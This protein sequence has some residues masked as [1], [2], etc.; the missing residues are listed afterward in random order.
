[1]HSLN[2]SVLDWQIMKLTLQLLAS[3]TGSTP[4]RSP[5]LDRKIF[6]FSYKLVKCCLCMCVEVDEKQQSK[7]SSQVVSRFKAPQEDERWQ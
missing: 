1:M 3:D 5:S 7:S 6:S 2:N 4:F